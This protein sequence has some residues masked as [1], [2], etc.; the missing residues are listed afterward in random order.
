MT[1]YT[2]YREINPIVVR[3]PTG[4]QVI[5]THSRTVKFTEFLHLE[6]VLYLPSFNFNLISISKLVSTLNCKLTFFSNS[7]LIQDISSQRMISA[8]SVVE[9]QYKLRVHAINSVPK[10]NNNFIYVKSVLSCNKEIIDVWHFH[11]SHPSYDRMQ[12]S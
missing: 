10:A 8:I 7:C 11:L 3:L 4:Q 12:L 5:A 1:C 2:T 9:S 6:D